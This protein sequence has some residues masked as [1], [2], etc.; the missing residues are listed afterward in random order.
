VKMGHVSGTKRESKQTQK[1]LEASAWMAWQ[2][3][4]PEGT[5]A[6]NTLPD[7]HIAWELFAAPI[8]T[9]EAHSSY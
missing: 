6:P 9:S 2:F 7:D 4:G 5:I 3:F 8:T 1:S